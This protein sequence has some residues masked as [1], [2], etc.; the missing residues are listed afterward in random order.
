MSTKERCRTWPCP[1]NRK[2]IWVMKADHLLFVFRKKA[3]FDIFIIPQMPSKVLSKITMNFSKKQE[4]P[5]SAA[6]K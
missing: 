6:G 3:I 1:A 4:Y 2:S 5:Q